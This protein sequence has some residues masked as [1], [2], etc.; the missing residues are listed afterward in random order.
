MWPS[1]CHAT[2][3]TPLPLHPLDAWGRVQV[4]GERAADD[5]HVESCGGCLSHTHMCMYMCTYT[6]I[7]IYIYTGRGTH[8]PA[9][10]TIIW[11]T[12]CCDGLQPAAMR[13]NW[14]HIGRHSSS[15]ASVRLRLVIRFAGLD[16]AVVPAGIRI[17]PRGVAALVL[18]GVV[19]DRQLLRLSSS[20]HQLMHMS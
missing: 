14:L 4:A 17:L 18:L 15:E 2:R 19:E 9:A 10:H 7:H 8:V 6:Y 12:T 13:Y 1:L 11:T 16:K 5:R 3:I 20:M